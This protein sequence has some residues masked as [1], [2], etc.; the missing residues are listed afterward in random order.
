M[1]SHQVAFKSKLTAGRMTG[2][3]HHG[4]GGTGDNQHNGTG[5]DVG[6]LLARANVR[7]DDFDIQVLQQKA[8][9]AEIKRLV[10][11]CSKY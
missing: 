9:Q 4:G 5:G 10:L 7:S 6:T 1:R 2:G 3:G 11:L 8:L